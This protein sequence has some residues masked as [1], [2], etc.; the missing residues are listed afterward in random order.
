M[1]KALK[2]AVQEF[3]AAIKESPAYKEFIALSDKISNDAE[4]QELLY[5]FQNKRKELEENDS[6]EIKD[7]LKELK[8]EIDSRGVF[9]EFAKAQER[10][11]ALLR[12][13]NDV[14]SDKI[15]TPFAQRK[16]GGCC[17]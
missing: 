6:E 14:I 2:V 9:K 15:Q 5:R 4:L 17:G 3:S 10:V 12:Q 16:G 13:T 11:V 8:R 7:E 1:D